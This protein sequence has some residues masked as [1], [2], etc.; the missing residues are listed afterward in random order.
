MGFVLVSRRWEL[1][2]PGSIIVLSWCMTN[3]VLLTHA[4]ERTFLIYFAFDLV[5]FETLAFLLMRQWA[6]W[7]LVFI[8]ATAGQLMLHVSY[9]AYEP[10][11][12]TYYERLNALF[13]IQAQATMFAS[14]LPIRRAADA[15][16]LKPRLEHVVTPGPLLIG[17]DVK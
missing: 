4:P 9:W 15:R 1:L 6:W 7:K 14:V 10:P 13:W 5:S 8:C 3:T 17:V 16:W 12:F 11:A 2:I